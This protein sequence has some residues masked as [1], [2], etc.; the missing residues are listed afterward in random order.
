MCGGAGP[1]NLAKPSEIDFT[2]YS[3]L[4]C[5]VIQT[6]KYASCSHEDAKTSDMPLTKILLSKDVIDEYCFLIWDDKLLFWV[7]F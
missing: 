5:Y 1:K 3:D 2:P 7:K 4:R 6:E